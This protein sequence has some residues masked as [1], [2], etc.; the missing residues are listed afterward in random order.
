MVKVKAQV[1]KNYA[2]LKKHVLMANLTGGRLPLV[3]NRCSANRDSRPDAIFAGHFQSCA[4]L[5]VNRK[6]SPP[7]TKSAR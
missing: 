5:R 3:W 1:K 6:P 2:G 7:S 4:R